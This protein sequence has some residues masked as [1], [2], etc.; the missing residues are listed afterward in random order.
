MTSSPEPCAAAW[1]PDL[2]ESSPVSGATTDGTW[3]LP[4]L[5]DE[6]A[7]AAREVGPTRLEQAYADGF[8]A[9]RREG[10][11]T[12]YEMLTPALGTLGGVVEALGEARERFMADR[13]HDLQALAIAVARQLFQREV[14][15]DPAVVRDLVAQALDQLPPDC[16]VDVRLSPVDLAALAGRLEELHASGRGLTLQWIADPTLER[17][18]FLLETPARIVDGRVDVALHALYERL[19]HE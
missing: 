18:S 15:S 11:A 3:L 8:G 19:D 10:E 17:G 4:D 6:A 7:P 16:T 5:A 2:D 9:G 13:I 14:Q 12:A 1:L